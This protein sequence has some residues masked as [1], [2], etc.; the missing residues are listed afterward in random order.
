MATYHLAITIVKHAGARCYSPGA[1][2]VARVKGKINAAMYR[3]NDNLLW[4]AL[5]YVLRLNVHLARGQ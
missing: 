1:G 4:S 3:L 2:R 5:V